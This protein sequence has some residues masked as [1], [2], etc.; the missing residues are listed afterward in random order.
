[1]SRPLRDA[2]ADSNGSE[3]VPRRLQ[4][5]NV[6]TRRPARPGHC[7]TAGVNADCQ[8]D[9]AGSWVFDR[10]EASSWQEAAE[11]CVRRC[12]S[13]ERCRYVS[14][15]LRRQDCSWFEHCNLEKLPNF[16]SGFRTLAV[17]P[18]R[19]L[20]PTANP[21]GPPHIVR[22]PSD[23]SSGL[24]R[25]TACERFEVYDFPSGFEL[26]AQ[27]RGIVI[28]QYGGR[29]S[30]CT[31]L[32][33]Y[34]LITALFF[35]R[36]LAF[37]LQPRTVLEMGCG[38][39]PVSDF[40]SRFTPGGAR[41]TCIEPEPML[42]ELFGR[43]T[44]PHRPTQLALDLFARTEAA[45]RCG[46]AL[47]GRRF[48]LVVSL[49]VAEHVS[50]D[51]RTTLVR[52][53]SAA[54]EKLLVFSAARKD[55]PGV[56]H[57]P[58]SM[59]AKASW[60][61]LFE[62]EGMVLLPKL[63]RIASKL[64]YPERACDLAMNVFVMRS[65]AVSID[66]EELLARGGSLLERRFILTSEPAFGQPWPWSRDDSSPMSD[67]MMQ[68]CMGGGVGPSASSQQAMEAALWPELSALRAALT[69]K[70]SGFKCR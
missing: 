25:G 65:P 41:V 63:S 39:G 3:A 32:K 12:N 43:R 58:A 60:I 9:D 55:Q 21:V 51:N 13:C 30:A 31:H 67:T 56:G 34:G 22:L 24:W 52:M 15:S 33:R 45:K 57:L 66:E 50:P 69:R 23:M 38:L 61:K 27:R 18:S 20:P 4:E 17:A 14:Y 48:E 44:M 46:E 36:F 2:V 47:I 53:I 29:W 16:V 59:L 64:A 49:E 40:L 54:T 1:M 7:G 28:G 70:G 26:F 6:S 35:M 62:A 11:A 8:V 68:D 42:Q 5:P 19:V 10:A 37:G